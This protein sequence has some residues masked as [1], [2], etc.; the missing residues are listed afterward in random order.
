MAKKKIVLIGSGRMVLT[1]NE[2]YTKRAKYLITQVKDD[3]IRY[4]LTKEARITD[5]KKALNVQCSVNLNKKI[6]LVLK[7]L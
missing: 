5:W 2:V 3:E 7:V 1:D 6:E 4:I